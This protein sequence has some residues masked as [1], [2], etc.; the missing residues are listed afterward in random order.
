MVDYISY[1]GSFIGLICLGLLFFRYKIHN[2]SYDKITS[3]N[4]ILY[5]ILLS[6]VFYVVSLYSITVA[7]K[8]SP[9][10]G[11]VNAI[12]AT[13]AVMVSILSYYIF[14]SHV[15]RYTLS[16]IVIIIFGLFIMF[17]GCPPDEVM[18]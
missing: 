7:I 13:N 2:V 5:P 4:R 14:K 10:P 9:N 6:S 15:N 11:Y 18:N 3:N 17:S 8:Q 12:V 16:G 1:V